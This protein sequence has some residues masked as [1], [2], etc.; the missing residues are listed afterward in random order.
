MTNLATKKSNYPNRPNQDSTKKEVYFVNEKLYQKTCEFYNELFEYFQRIAQG[1]ALL[2]IGNISADILRK[3]TENDFSEV[4]NRVYSDIEENL[5]KTHVSNQLLLDKLRAGL[6]EPFKMWRLKCELDLSQVNRI[7]RINPSI[8]FDINVYSFKDGIISFSDSD[9]QRIKTEKCTVYIDSD[10]KKD[11][12]NLSE[13][14]LKN[15]QSLKLILQKNGI[16]NLFGD[17]GLFS[18]N[19]Q[20]NLNKQ[21]LGYIKK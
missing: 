16:S 9:R 18:E 15:L 11:F 3:L 4:S 10:L 2:G 14:T 13:T 20:V 6:D 1:F 7:R 12:L 19:D 8:E 21:I 17:E 5:K